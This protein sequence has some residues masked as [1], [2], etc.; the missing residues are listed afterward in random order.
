MNDP[1]LSLDPLYDCIS[2]DGPVI[3]ILFLSYRCLMNKLNGVI[4]HPLG[5]VDFTYASLNGD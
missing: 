1:K 2:K 3:P 4:L 5:F